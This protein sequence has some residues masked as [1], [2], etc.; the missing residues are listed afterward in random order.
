MV[1]VTDTIAQIVIQ[2]YYVY[3]IR[4]NLMEYYDSQYHTSAVII[5]VMAVLISFVTCVVAR[6]SCIHLVIMV[7]VTPR[8]RL[9][10]WS[11]VFMS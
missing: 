8:E 7:M 3:V 10:L 4:A 2:H 5:I 11:T 1:V 6:L 9:E